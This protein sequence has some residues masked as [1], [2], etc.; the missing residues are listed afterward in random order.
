MGKVDWDMKDVTQVATEMYKAFPDQT[1][2][3]LKDRRFSGNVID[4]EGDGNNVDTVKKNF[5]FLK[6]I[7]RMWPNKV[8]SGYLLADV[9]ISLDQMFKGHLLKGNNIEQKREKALEEATKLKALNGY[10]RRLTVSRTPNSWS[11]EIKELKEV[12]KKR[13]HSGATK[14]PLENHWPC[15]SADE[16]IV[17]ADEGIVKADAKADAIEETLVGQ[18]MIKKRLKARGTV[19]ADEIGKTDEIG[20]AAE[21]GE[22]NDIGK[23]DESGEA[24]AIG[25]DDEQGDF[26]TVLASH[27]CALVDLLGDEESIAF[28]ELV[29]EGV[30]ATTMDMAVA[31]T[32]L[33]EA[34][35][36]PASSLDCAIQTPSPLPCRALSFSG[37]ESEMKSASGAESEMIISSKKSASAPEVIARGKAE[38]LFPSDGESTGRRNVQGPPMFTLSL[39]TPHPSACGC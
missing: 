3:F 23:D 20:K 28:H 39:S 13:D 7:V 38:K 8:C 18:M 37:A 4:L 14:L 5:L 27:V 2:I 10:V 30:F 17:N 25:N 24:N 31:L 1:H 36:P 19:K 16:S 11:P 6:A 9:L 34:R 33:C 26:D 22:G 12:I 29:S 35:S 32:N 21:V 15:D